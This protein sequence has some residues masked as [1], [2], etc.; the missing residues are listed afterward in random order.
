ML[1]QTLKSI[2]ALTESYPDL[3]ANQNFLKLQEELSETEDQIAASRRIYNS[4]VQFYN[5]QCE[6]FPSNL[7]ASHYKFN[8]SIYFELNDK[9]KDLVQKVPE[10]NL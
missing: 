4:N 2:F 1:T 3:K 7:I 10:V 6:V 5:T 8:K 9:E